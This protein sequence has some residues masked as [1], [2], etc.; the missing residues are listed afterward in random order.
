MFN[1]VS[2]NPQIISPKKIY[3]YQGW[4]KN[5]K[6]DGTLNPN[7]PQCK[8]GNI[9]KTIHFIGDCFCLHEGHL[10]TPSVLDTYVQRVIQHPSCCF[11]A[12]F[13]LFLNYIF[14]RNLVN[15]IFLKKTLKPRHKFQQVAKQ[16]QQQG[17]QIFF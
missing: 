4:F 12:T 8:L 1:F 10:Q 14:F 6:M 16:Q 13:F 15:E 3:C 17:C 9:F 2:H 11:L 7:P 5:P